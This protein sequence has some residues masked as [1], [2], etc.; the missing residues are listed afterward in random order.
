M[1]GDRRYQAVSELALAVLERRLFKLI[2]RADDAADF[3]LAQLKYE[4][5]GNPVTRRRIEQRAAKRAALDRGWKAVVWLPNPDMRLKVAEVLV[6]NEEGVAPLDAVS[7]A[8]GHI[9]RQHRRLW[10][11]SIYAP[12][13]RRQR[14]EGRDRAVVQ[15]QD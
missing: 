10:A 6:Q 8:G 11:I 4:K 15:H 7:D 2:G 5:F 13:R 1:N 9:V 3:A 12:A 14:R